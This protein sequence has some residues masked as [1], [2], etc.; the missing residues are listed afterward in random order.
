MTVV[1]GTIAGYFFSFNSPTGFNLASE[2]KSVASLA[3]LYAIRMLGLF[4]VLPV[5]FVHGQDYSGASIA[6]LGLVLGIYGLAQACCQIPLGLLSD[7]IGRKPIIVFGLLLFGIGSV[8]GALTDSVVGLIIA[9]ILQGAGA[10]AS[11]VMALVA[12]LTSD[13]NRTKAMAAIGASIGL[14]FALAM[15]L[16]PVLAA[17]GGL[18]AIFWTTAVLAVI[19]ILIAVFIVPSPTLRPQLNRDTGAVPMLL[20]STALQPQ[21]ARL[22]YGIFAL[23]AALTAL[24]VVIPVALVET[25][26]IVKESHWLV[27]LPVLLGS[28]VLSLPLMVVSEKRGLGK[29]AFCAA[30]FAL[31]IVLLCFAY[32]ASSSAFLIL[33]F[34]YFVAFNLLEAMLPSLVSKAAPTAS[35]GT[36]MGVYSTCQ[37]LGAFCGGAI[38]GILVSTWS[39]VVLFLSAAALVFVWLSVAI[40]L[41]WPARL[42]NI[43]YSARSE[44]MT[45]NLTSFEGVEDAVYISD[46]QSLYI[47]VDKARLDNE[48]LQKTLMPYL[49]GPDGSKS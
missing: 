39:S 32:A 14:S 42:T 5:I 10:I 13:K 49:V 34:V 25:V 9:R 23:H 33:L 35:K 38:G 15:V 6:S 4:M 8:L 27:Y 16:G 20:M 45:L 3:L 41:N 19:G 12:D 29:Q 44:A 43:R 22:N 31:G 18:S 1:V 7:M 46:E 17:V 37:F 47:K 30:I 11:T 28:F 24:F 40:S 26:G 2:V 48:A 36:A 21:L